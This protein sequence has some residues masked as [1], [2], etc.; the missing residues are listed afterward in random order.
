MLGMMAGVVWHIAGW[1]EHV[2]LK[3]KRI[4]SGR[5]TAVESQYKIAAGVCQQQRQHWEM[6]QFQ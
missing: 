3:C 6:D 5:C 1:Y 2:V 4:T